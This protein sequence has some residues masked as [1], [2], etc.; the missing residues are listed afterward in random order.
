MLYLGCWRLMIELKGSLC[1]RQ[2]FQKQITKSTRLDLVT[3]VS[4]GRFFLYGLEH[5]AG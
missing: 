2:Q 1:D 5:S 4:F 3:A